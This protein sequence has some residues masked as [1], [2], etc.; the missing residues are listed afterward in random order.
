MTGA[1][2][3]I[4]ISCVITVTLLLATGCAQQKFR[5]VQLPPKPWLAHQARMQTIDHW[6]VQGKLGYRNSESSGSAWFD[7]I[8]EGDNF[9][10][11]LSGPFGT[12]T[13]KIS[14]TPL[15]VTLS[16]PGKD[17]LSA[18]SSAVLTQNLFGWHLPVEQLRYWARGIPANASS[19]TIETFNEQGQINTLVQDNWEIN[20][21]R[22]QTH[23]RGQLPG[24]I[25]ARNDN[26]TFTLLLKD[27]SFPEL[28]SL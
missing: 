23:S 5:T 24:K 1:K 15:I 20:M 13:V 4:L 26:L 27:W 2:S 10:I 18:S 9:T 11:Y 28:G 25:K 21:S 22:Y 17:D 7:W 8:Q 16:Q 14:G 12:G 19:S 3:S 6:Q